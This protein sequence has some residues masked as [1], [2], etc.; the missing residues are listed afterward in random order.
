V[1]NRQ[2]V[3]SGVTFP[4]PQPADPTPATLTR[5]GAQE[6]FIDATMEEH[7]WLIVANS[8]YPGWRAWA[9]PV[10]AGDD[11]EQEVPVVRVNGNFMGT[12][13]QPG[14][15]TIRLKFSPDSFRFGAFASFLTFMALIFAL[16]VYVY[17]LAYT[18]QGEGAH[19]QRV[20]KNTVTPIALNLFNKGIQFVLTFA[21]LRILGPEKAGDYRY[22]I[23]IWGWF[24]ILSNFGLNTF[25]MREVARH[26]DEAN[27][28]L[29]NTTILRLML[30]GIGLPA[31]A[32]FLYIRQTFITPPQN[33]A[34]LITIGILYGGLFFSTIS[35][36]LTALF[37][38]YER[39]EVPA[40]VQTVSAFLTTALGIT[41]LLLGWGIIGLAGVS[42]TVNLI[43]FAVLGTL[44]LRTFFKPKW[45]F[46]WKLQRE[47]LGESFPLMLNHLLA[48]LFFRID[49]VLLEAISG[50]IVVGWYS[51]V[52]TW[53]DAIMVIPSF[54]TLSLF[55][56]MSR[57][58]ID[59][60]PAL[61]RAY[62]LAV[63]L[64]TLISVP[65][66][67]FTTLLAPFLINVLG[68][69]QYL[70]HGAI[71]LQIFI[72]SILIGWINSVTQYVIIALN[73]QRTLTIIFVV[74]AAFNIIANLITI[75]RY[76]YPAA[77]FI[78]ILSEFVLWGMFTV[79][80]MSELGRVN[81][82][83]ALWRIALA[84]VATGMVTFL[85]GGINQWLGFGA[86]VIVYAA[87]F[88][89]LRPLD[90]EELA[91]L[92]PVLP[93][94]VRRRLLPCIEQVPTD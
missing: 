20:A 65:T 75:P 68:G 66:A 74:A 23:V 10:G 53:V 28:Y 72:W 22:A 64:M 77:A 24:E 44:A 82:L 57:Q 42:V 86:G 67:I 87:A 33:P 14:E 49:V 19:I 73:R 17:R 69:P 21:M 18:E 63:K 46:N 15:W 4:A 8:Y 47:A 16:G 81:W 25:L 70:P 26:K 38:A 1:V 55:P 89:V 94:V 80:L 79:V 29:I 27:R 83:A 45:T 59:D 6:L 37:Y 58:A 61:K 54:F 48:T 51:T 88:F 56:V 92:A 41:A 13:L 35:T 11:A 93:G 91:R 34:T 71:A 9:R 7:S 52:Y 3:P 39:A 40:A 60:R 43:T 90:R 36:G 31:L 2:D 84:G 85:L 32:A 5:Y 50:A 62:L 30:A 78:T 12:L 76:S